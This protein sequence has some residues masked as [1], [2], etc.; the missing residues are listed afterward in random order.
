MPS[1]NHIPR[2]GIFER[3]LNYKGT[4]DN[5]FQTGIQAAFFDEAG[6]RYSVDGFY[7]GEE[8]YKVRF[9][10]SMP[11]LWEY[12][13][14]IDGNPAESGGFQCVP[15]TLKGPLRQDPRHPCH[16]IFD[17]GEPFYMLGN[18]AYQAV[19]AYRDHP[20]QFAA[21]LDYYAARSFNWNR[22]VV[23]A[24][25]SKDQ[26]DRWIWGG[27][28]E[29]PDYAEFDLDTFR[30]VE[31]VIEEMAARDMI[32]SLI[33]MVDRAYRSTG[34]QKMNIARRYLKY[35]VARVGAWWNVVWNL[36]NEWNKNDIFTSA[37]VDELGAYLRSIDP[38]RRLTACHHYARFEFFDRDWA[39]YA[40]MQYRDLPGGINKV[41]LQNR[42]FGKIVANEEYG[43]EEDTI[44]PPN[45][46][47]NVRHDH[48]AIAMAG[49]YGTYGDK[50]KGP[51]IGVYF[52]C[53]LED[54]RGTS[55]PDALRHLYSFMMQTGYRDMAP[56][57]HFLS[58]CNPEEVFCLANPGREYIVY[59]VKGQEVVLNLAHVRRELQMQWFD[60][61][62]GSFSPPQAVTVPQNMRELPGWEH[63][64][65]S[66]INMHR[67]QN[68][69]FQPPGYDQDWVLHLKACHP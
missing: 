66:F 68:I 61:L 65:R 6:R 22:F 52:T 47:D 23:A 5:P 1:P 64:D 20:R 17:N 46:A 35:M 18:T 29:E 55:A 33:F 45:D 13:I 67:R 43:Y 10:P 60:P 16:F 31:G 11:G 63:G 15:S 34:A 12:R 54:A 21:F 9:M 30:A 58:R 32:A 24:D 53:N 7:D 19:A 4:G 69:A 41:M 2:Y 56:G 59:M 48:W 14:F 44:L 25:R 62:T 40:S 3:S 57:N 26:V 50:T 42:Y 51:K 36:F 49:G 37:E 38:Y 27:T 39:D 28:Q 8:T